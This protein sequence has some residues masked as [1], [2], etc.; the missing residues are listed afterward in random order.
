MK[1]L[2]GIVLVALA[3]GVVSATAQNVKTDV[4]RDA[5]AVKNETKKDAK[6]IA[7]K[8]A[9][10]SSKAKSKI[11]DKTYSDKVGRNGQTIYIDKHDKY[12]WVDKKGHKNY[13]TEADLKNK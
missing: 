13:V 1:K 8:T 12:Y 3:L 4:K 11:T 6:K 5:T 10:T 2:I 7:N 9:E